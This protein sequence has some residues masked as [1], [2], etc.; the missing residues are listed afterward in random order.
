MKLFAKYSR[1]NVVATVIIFL[2]ACIAFYFTLHYVLMSQIDQDLKIEQ[3]EIET[4]VKEHSRLPEN[5][6]VKDQMIRYQPIQKNL[7][8]RFTTRFIKEHDGDGGGEKFRQLAFST[9]VGQQWY[10]AT[11]SKSLEATEN[12]TQSILIIA[13]ITI[14]VIL[15]VTFL[16]N[17]I[18]LKRIWKPF[19]QSLDAVKDF[20]VGE[21][22]A[23]QLS[24]SAI[25]EFQ[26]MNQTLEK[27]TR[28]AKLDYLSLKT[29][30][31][32]ASHEIQTPLAV[33]RSKLDLIVQDESLTQKQS[34][35]LQAA[36]NSLQ[37][38]TR[39]NQSLLLLAKIENNQFETLQ[40]VDL[41]SMLQ[42]KVTDFNEL[43]QTENI[44]LHAD[45]LPA[46]VSMNKDLAEILI[47][48]LLSNATRHN[49]NGGEISISLTKNFLEI[50]NTST[51]SMLIET[52]LYRRFLKPIHQ[53][54]SNGLGLSIIKQISDTSG[55]SIQY[56]FNE[57]KHRFVIS[58]NAAK[59]Y[60]DESKVNPIK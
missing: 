42:E 32:N 22:A 9:K 53:S 37:K 26:L 60:R 52:M 12:L 27:I 2:I 14:L 48:N 4:F 20:K 39:L 54:D 25:N 13:F 58:F 40:S 28:Q 44:S 59:S 1:I 46:V 50:A 10:Q 29:F 43:W 18:V 7:T 30:S 3:R 19:Y 55:F 6:S 16:I 38:L 23:L 57:N 51:Q 15:L 49:Y 17:R 34:E 56:S 45:L 35:A 41:K 47:N 21:T 24:P 36:Y 33:I 31:E 5:I 8:P 11:V